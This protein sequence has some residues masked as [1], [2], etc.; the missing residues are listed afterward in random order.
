MFVC[1]ARASARS[2][3]PYNSN[4]LRLPPRRP[5]L[6]HAHFSEVHERRLEALDLRTEGSWQKAVD[7]FDDR[8][9]GRMALH[10]REFF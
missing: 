7:I 2:G 6:R 8:V 4:R 9:L 5:N 3:S 10:S 1:I